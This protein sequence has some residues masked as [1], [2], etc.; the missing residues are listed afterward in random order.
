MST[1]DLRSTQKIVSLT[2]GMPN[3]DA[4]K[5]EDM[6]TRMKSIEQSLN[7]ILQKLNK[8]IKGENN[9]G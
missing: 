1:Y 3:G 9:N 4:S 5:I 7:L 2:P 6:E 8:D